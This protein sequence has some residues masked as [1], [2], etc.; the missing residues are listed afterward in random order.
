MPDLKGQKG[1]VKFTLEITRAA[2]GKKETVDMIGIIGDSPELENQPQLWEH[3]ER[4][5][6]E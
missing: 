4:T 2:T 5:K 3:D 6:P 1:E